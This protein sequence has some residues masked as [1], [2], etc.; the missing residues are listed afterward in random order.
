M[1]QPA[2]PFL[3]IISALRRTA[4]LMIDDL[5]ARLDA[6]GFEG[7]SPSHQ[8]VFENL[9]PDGTRITELAA[10]AGITQQ[11]M[12]ELVSVLEHRGYLERCVDTRDRRARLVRLTPTGRRMARR[13]IQEI[14]AIETD[15]RELLTRH[16]V[17]G[18][19]T[20]AFAQAL[21]DRPSRSAG[22]ASDRND[23]S[24]AR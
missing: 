2:G 14:A 8:S 21:A 23:R 5:I 15:W 3:T 9:D 13:A 4:T 11:S 24:A 6:A 19:I 20:A 1:T 7:L 16:G 22:K 17:S 10:R 18:D 12:S